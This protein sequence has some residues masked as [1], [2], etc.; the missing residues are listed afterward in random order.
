MPRK[1]PVFHKGHYNILAAQF[2]DELT[3]LTGLRSPAKRAGRNAVIELALSLARRLEQDNPEFDALQFLNA[4][5][6]DP[7]IWPLAELWEGTIE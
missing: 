1:T 2:K 7:E 6:P 4:C 3:K 5:S